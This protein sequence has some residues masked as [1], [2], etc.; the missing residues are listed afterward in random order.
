MP[1]KGWAWE[2]ASRIVAALKYHHADGQI[3][4]EVKGGRKI[5]S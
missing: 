4:V 1:G 5:T 2:P 3:K